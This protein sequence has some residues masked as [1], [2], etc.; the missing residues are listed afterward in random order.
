MTYI[1][2]AELKT[3]IGPTD[4][5]NFT[6]AQLNSKITRENTKINRELNVQVVRER[7]TYINVAKQNQIDGTTTT[8]FVRNW[9]G[10]SFGDSTNDGA[11]TIADVVV[12]SRDADGTETPLTV[13]SID[14]DNMSFTL[15][16]APASN[17]T[18]FATYKYS[19]YDMSTPDQN[20]K[21]LA[22]YLCLSSVYFDIEFDL[23]GTSQKAG[24]ISIAGLDKNTKTHKYK[25]KANELLSFLKSFGTGKRRPITF[26]I[27][28]QRRYR[29]ERHLSDPNSGEYPYY[30]YY[31]DYY[32]HDRNYAWGGY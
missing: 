20:I 28:L 4:V 9:F 32:P 29:R 2:L 19:Y 14:N 31:P 30:G 3:A 16:S 12:V 6:D 1:T 22:R 7:V 10:F 26:N 13:S 21:E 8:F 23:I 15:S 17:L 25:N 24:N 11:I 18:L 27:A 5:V